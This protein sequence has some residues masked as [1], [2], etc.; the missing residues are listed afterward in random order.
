MGHNVA[1]SSWVGF[2][3]RDT[4]VIAGV[5][6]IAVITRVDICLPWHDLNVDKAEVEGQVGQ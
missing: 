2:G 6:V 4:A 5:A 1:V 3:Y